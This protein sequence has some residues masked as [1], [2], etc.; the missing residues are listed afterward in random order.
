M[1]VLLITNPHPPFDSVWKLILGP[2]GGGMALCFM[3]GIIAGWVARQ[4]VFEKVVKDQDDEN[5]KRIESL[6]MRNDS[7][8]NRIAGQVSISTPPA[9]T[10]PKVNASVVTRPE[11]ENQGES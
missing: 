1:T 3:V 5:K 6:Q 7:L 10:L 11:S 2:T 4:R 9:Q 8:W